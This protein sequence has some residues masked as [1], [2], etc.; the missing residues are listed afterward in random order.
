MY[1][2]LGLIGGI[3]YLFMFVVVNLGGRSRGFRVLF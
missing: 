1:E 2:V 3:K